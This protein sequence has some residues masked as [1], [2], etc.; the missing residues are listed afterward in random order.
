MEREWEGREE[1]QAWQICGL[2]R[3]SGHSHVPFAFLLEPIFLAEDEVAFE[4]LERGVEKVRPS[5]IHKSLAFA[6]HFSCSRLPFVQ[7]SHFHFL[8]ITFHHPSRSFSSE[9]MSAKFTTM[10]RSMN[11][12]WLCGVSRVPKPCKSRTR[13]FIST[14]CLP[15]TKRRRWHSLKKTW[16]LT[17]QRAAVR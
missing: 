7:R 16:P 8:A 9:Q 10:T 6:L 14:P 1:M 17:C 2:N 3:N 4:L 15:K 11:A 12:S 5:V 13:T